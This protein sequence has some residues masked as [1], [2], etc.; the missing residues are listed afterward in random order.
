[1]Q[2]IEPGAVKIAINADRK[3]PVFAN[4]D[5]GIVAD[6]TELIPRLFERLHK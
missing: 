1:M 6:A 5:L 3:A 4:V 2:G